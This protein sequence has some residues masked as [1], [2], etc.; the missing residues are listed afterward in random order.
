[1]SIPVFELESRWWA[2][3]SELRP[4]ILCLSCKFSWKRLS[5]ISDLERLALE[6]GPCPNCAAYTLVCIS[7][8]SSPDHPRRPRGIASRA[9]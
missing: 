5:V 4:M 6:S 9:A 8:N 7:T 3:N 1:M 2:V